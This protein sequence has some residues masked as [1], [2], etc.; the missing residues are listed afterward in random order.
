MST[1]YQWM[2]QFREEDSARGDLAR[3]MK[4]DYRRFPKKKNFDG[5]KEY[6]VRN[7]ACKN[8]LSV[9]FSAG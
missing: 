1:F 5:I 6:L 9:F 2:K 8:C 3:D 7:G 4:T